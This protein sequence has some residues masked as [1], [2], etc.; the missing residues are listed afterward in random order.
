MDEL[1]VQKQNFLRE[2]EKLHARHVLSQEIGEDHFEPGM[3]EYLEQSDGIYEE[4]TGRVVIRFES[5]GTK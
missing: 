2:I 1:N 3:M 4:A 5:K